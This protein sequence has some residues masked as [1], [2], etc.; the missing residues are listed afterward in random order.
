MK[1]ILS[2]TLFLICS[3]V[4]QAQLLN[5]EL[6][7]TGDLSDFKTSFEKI[8]HNENISI[9]KLN[10]KAN[11]PTQI[12]PFS[13]EFRIPSIDIESIWNTEFT[14]Q[15]QKYNFTYYSRLGANAPIISFINNEDQ[16]RFSLATSDLVNTSVFSHKIDEHYNYFDVEIQ[17]FTEKPAVE[18][19]TEYELFIRVDNGSHTLSKTLADINQWWEDEKF[20][21]PQV[22][23]K[24]ATDPIYS[25]WY[26]FH[27]NME[28][29]ELLKECR[30]AAELGYKTVIIDDGWSTTAE[31]RNG[32][33][34]FAFA[35]DYEVESFDKDMKSL[36]DSIHAL[37]MKAM[38][39]FCGSF[40]G[41]NSEAY[42]KFK[43]KTIRQ[44]SW[45]GFYN[46]DIRYPEVREHF[47]Q[48]FEDAFTD[49]GIDGIKVDFL[50][51]FYFD[52]EN[53]RTAQDGRDYASLDEAMLRYM[54]DMHN[55]I[56][57]IKPD[58]L[59]EFRQAYST[60]TMR[61]YGNL[62]RAIDC[63]NMEVV[64]RYYVT[65]LRMVS[66]ST[67]IT[68]DMF[69]W[70]YDEP[71]E[72]AAM[73]LLNVIFSVPQLSVKIDSITSDQKEMVR[74]YTR[75]YNENKNT[76]LFGEFEA[77]GHLAEYP[78]ISSTL[79]GKKIIGIYDDLVVTSSIEK[80]LYLINAK[81]SKQLVF[82]L[83]ETIEGK[84]K[85]QIFNCK[86]ELVSE[87]DYSNMN[88]GLHQ[89]DVP[90]AGLIKIRN[91]SGLQK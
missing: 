45:G 82:N 21:E 78:L 75:F 14:T 88:K 17:F 27:E 35:G 24:A 83:I 86:G 52:A 16:N 53:S 31:I 26:A 30:L 62:F 28:T 7:L 10:L 1:K 69:T 80:E 50:S 42:Q 90:S 51:Q 57:K 89:F 43:N 29:E 5:P 25:T 64:N 48:K 46:V 13:I 63:A 59:V 38:V 2:S 22:A 9:Y 60:P 91:S 68:S 41:E 81:N 19:K 67:P 3:L 70:H 61:K 12:P 77:K 18:K 84:I 71:V 58:A 40:V 33:P 11:Q 44:S 56:T 87:N 65:K 85:V 72:S 39:W 32:Q 73:Q 76:L 79:N 8:E 20:I 36:I 37:G 54:E 74:F 49:W 15:G 4:I 55:T 66:G 47:I 23:P 6:K 34:S